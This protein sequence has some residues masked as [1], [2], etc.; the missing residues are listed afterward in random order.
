MRA[1]FVKHLK[2][3]YKG[4]FFFLILGSLIV[5]S[6]YIQFGY[7]DMD[8][9][10]PEGMSSVFE[11]SLL[12][13]GAIYIIGKYTQRARRLREMTSEVL[14]F[15]IVA[16]GFLG[17][18]A[19]FFKEKEMGVFHALGVLPSPIWKELLIKL[20]VFWLFDMLF[21]ILL[22]TINFSFGETITLWRVFFP[23]TLLS[24]SM[25]ILGLVASLICK[26][27]KQF[28]VIY[29]VL[30]ILLT[31]PLFLSANTSFEIPGIEYN[32]LYVLYVRI[33]EL[34]FGGSLVIDSFYFLFIGGFVVLGWVTYRWYK[35]VMQYG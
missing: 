32:Y 16:V 1:S 34:F 14:F 30:I 13:S 5:Y 8:I 26:N 17:I 29:T 4:K 2:L 21:T 9:P 28:G 12:D 18:V 15:E 10:A 33:K 19:L 6:A 35:K 31:S 3:M 27:F 20:G 24:L 25:T 22:L 23:V 7:A 11:E